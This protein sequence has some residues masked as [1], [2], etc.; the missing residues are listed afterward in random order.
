MGKIAR[1]WKRQ[2]NSER[3]EARKIDKVKAEREREKA[4][5]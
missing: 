4:T 3:R 1:E 5:G 2:K